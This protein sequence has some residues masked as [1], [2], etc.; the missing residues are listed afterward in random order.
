MLGKTGLLF[1]LVPAAVITGC[2]VNSTPSDAHDAGLG[3]S[4]GS[5]GGG[6]DSGADSGPEAGVVAACSNLE[7]L[8]PTCQALPDRF[9]SSTTLAKGCYAASKTPTIA[10]GVTLTLSPGVTILFAEDTKILVDGDRTLLAEGTA[11]EPICMTGDKATRGWWQ[12]LVFGHNETSSKLAHVTIEYAGSTKSDST[13]AAIKASTDS[14]GLALSITNTTV[15]E[16]QGYG[17]YLGGSSQLEAFSKNTFTKNTL[18]PAYVDSETA[19]LLDST[20]D[21]TG[22]DVDEVTVSSYSLSKNATW[23]SLGVPYHLIG[24]SGMNVEVPWTVEAPNTVIMPSAVLINISGDDASL[25]AVGAADKPIVF[26]G[27]K[28]ERGFWEGLVF[29]GSMNAANKLDYVT[30]EYAGSTL[31]DSTNAAV[32]TK[33]DSHGV[34]L[35]ITNTTIHE[36]QGYGLYLIGSAQLPAFA[37][38]TFT[39]N[40]LGPVSVGSEAAHQL[41]VTSKYTGNDVDRVRVTG[42]SVSKTVT[43]A[44]LGVPYQLES[45]IH[46]TM[47]WTLAPAVTL[48]MAKDTSI[49]VDGDDAG[50]H[51]VGTAVKPITITGL[52]KTAGYWHCITFGSTLN[53][54]NSLEY[55]TIEYGGST[56]GGGEKGMI[57]LLSDSHG[58]SASVK[59][60]TIKDSARYG[61]YLGLYAK[62]NNDI[63]S[64]NTF[65][66]NAL[67]NVFKA[68]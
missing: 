49:S 28:K 8:R 30:V 66:N 21:Y 3:G 31:S 7:A 6:A 53:S 19:G 58:V 18:G 36:S 35:S 32:K 27:E 33:G 38:N 51:A 14:S 55:A 48:M 47:V 23:K 50:F 64:G 61:I 59:S 1:L 15:R 17:L 2:N 34:S 63:E 29:Y 12:G 56:G 54:A 13:N 57:N 25:T 26:T 44:D 39:K 20:S 67:G 10:A 37:N 68:Q 11:Q 9:D 16:S 40:T 43:W 42:A 41:S 62:Y 24:A 45:G 4:G 60:C 46:V 52:E 5:S 22:N 65:S